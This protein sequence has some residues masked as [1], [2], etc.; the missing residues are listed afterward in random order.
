MSVEVKKWVQITHWLTNKWN[1]TSYNLQRTNNKQR[2]RRGQ[3]T[4]RLTSPHPSSLATHPSR[5]LK[6]LKAMSSM[7]FT[8][9]SWPGWT[10]SCLRTSI[11]TRQ[12][13]NSTAKSLRSCTASRS[14]LHPVSALVEEED[15]RGGLEEVWKGWCCYVKEKWRNEGRKG[16][17][18]K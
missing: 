15:G 12:K 2:T 6:C 10:A 11:W 16:I 1:F 3:T 17:K 13:M 4:V 18:L 9:S 8:K 7:C 14:T 5:Y